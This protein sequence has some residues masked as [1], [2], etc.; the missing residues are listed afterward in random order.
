MLGNYTG[1]PLA[2]LCNIVGGINSSSIITLSTDVDGASGILTYEQVH[3]SIITPQY[4]ISTGAVI[5]GQQPM[6]IL[7]YK[8]NGTML[9]SDGS[10]LGS[11]TDLGGPLRA[12]VVSNNGTST[13]LACDGMATFGNN[14]IKAI[15]KIVITI[16]ST[17][18]YNTVDEYGDPISSFSEGNIVYFSATGLSASTNYTLSTVEHSSLTM[19]IPFPSS[20]SAIT[21]VATD[22]SGEINIETIYE[23]AAAGSSDILIDVNN[24]GVFDEPDILVYNIADN[25]FGFSVE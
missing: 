23:E 24:N 16:P 6:W 4:N 5:T 21:S 20:I 2:V 18:S 19:R 8:V 17:L 10:G 11:N 22:A 12:I 3:D 9:S 1:V 13:D 15:T 14:Y 25:T 7:A